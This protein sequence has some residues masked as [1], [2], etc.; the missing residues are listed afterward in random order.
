[1]RY[2]IASNTK[3]LIHVSSG[4][5]I[6]DNNFI[7][8]RRCLDTFII[9]ICTQG[10]LYIAQDDYRYILKKNQYLV[11]FAGHEH[12]GYRKSEGKT[13]YYW[14]HFSPG[15]GKGRVIDRPGL[16]KIIHPRYYILPEY[17]DIAD[18]GKTIFIFRQLLDYARSK[19]YSENLPNYALS[20]LAMEISQEFI[21]RFIVQ[22][23]KDEINPHI[24]RVVEWVRINYNRNYT[25][26]KIASIFNYN[27]NYLSNAFRNYKQIPL[28]KYIAIAKI[29]KAKELLVG[30][31]FTIKEIAWQV[32]FS[33][34]KT[35]MKRF[36][37]I[38]NLSPTH[39]R[40]AYS[41]VKLVR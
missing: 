36:K 13:A 3:P 5:L 17:G 38:E 16:L 21:D 11:L 18:N 35:F 34:E 41:R 1:M 23:A 40:N 6:K 2:F 27:P 7:L 29:N 4:Q 33:D 30:T 28:M 26:K 24:E 20:L 32:G 10:T 8:Q 37:L 31:T 9:V 12:R 22:M 19:C 39:F 25:L 15:G 14:C